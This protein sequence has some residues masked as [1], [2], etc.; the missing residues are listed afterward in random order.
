MKAFVPFVMTA[1]VCFGA[2]TT[3]FAQDAEPTTEGLPATLG[4]IE[5]L[6][7]ALDALLPAD[8]KTEVLAGG[9][10]WTEGP[11]WLPAEKALVFSDIPRNLIFRWQEGQPVSVFKK[12]VGYT[13][14]EPFLG[15]EPGTNGLMLDPQGRLTACCHGDRC[16]KRINAD[17]TLETLVAEYEGK[18]L[19]SPNDLDFNKAGE[20]FFTDPPYGLPKGWDDP[21]RQIDFCGVYRLGADGKL[22]LMTK[23][24]TRPNGIA[25]SPDFKN[26][27][28]ANSDPK[29]AIWKRF[30]VRDDGTLDNGQLF[31]DATDKVNAENPGLPDG[32]AVDAKGNVWATGPGGVWIFDPNGK[33][34]GRIFTG[35][36]TSNCTFGGPNGTTLYMTVDD[37]L[38]R[39][40]T[41]VTGAAR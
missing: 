6:D 16:V 22:T 1:A 17:G 9:F 5:R 4:K 8:A 25:F 13:G 39:I 3:A 23:E 12:E 21:A 15:E 14:K 19:N 36:R 10:V 40:E 7:P 29:I 34:L 35:E 38:C 18:H 24:M 31:F 27:Y 28:V 2:A 33:P 11:E 41:S 20:L 37:Y 26:L 30:P 32:M